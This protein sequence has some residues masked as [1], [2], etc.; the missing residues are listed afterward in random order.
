[1]AIFID[2]YLIAKCQHTL[3]E[4]NI[5]SIFATRLRF[6]RKFKRLSQKKLGI[7]AGINESSASS[8]E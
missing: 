3:M 1:M 4:L 2:Q 5:S 7:L 8:A 6:A